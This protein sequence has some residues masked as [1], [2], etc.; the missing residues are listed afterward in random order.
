MKTKLIS[1][2]AFFLIVFNT[3]TPPRYVPKTKDLDVNVY[4]S[5]IIIKPIKGSNVKG[6]LL[7]VDTHRL[8]VL[9]DSGRQKKVSF[10]PLKKVKNFTLRYAQPKSYWWTVGAYTALCISHGIWALVSVP[11]NL[12]ITGGIAIGATNEFKFHKDDIPYDSL[13]MFARFPEGIP[14]DVVINTKPK[15]RVVPHRDKPKK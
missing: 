7:A 1:A 10:F 2:L 13:K 12:I 15:P 5:Y 6:E 9:I 8:V 4:G 11:V 14:P 3:C